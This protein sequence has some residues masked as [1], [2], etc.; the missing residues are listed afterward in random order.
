MYGI[1][2]LVE[3]IIH[4]FPILTVSTHMYRWFKYLWG[5]SISV[6]IRK[7]PHKCGVRVIDVHANLIQRRESLVLEAIISS[8]S[9]RVRSWDTSNTCPL[10]VFLDYYVLNIKTFIM[11]QILIFYYWKWKLLATVLPSPPFLSLPFPSLPLSSLP[12]PSLPLSFLP[13]PF[14]PFLSH[15]LLL[16]ALPIAMCSVSASSEMTFPPGGSSRI[17]C[18]VHIALGNLSSEELLETLW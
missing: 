11:F 14:L 7:S 1:F 15:I 13:F 9:W 16:Y 10:S 5:P 2:F 17:S 3:S 4:S 6:L 12:F 8:I 18:K